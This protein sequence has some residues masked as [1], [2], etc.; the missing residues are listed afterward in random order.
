MT[1][2]TVTSKGQVTIPKE[3]RE[4]LG[5]KDRDRIAFIVEGKRAVIIPM[6]TTDLIS[7][8]GS[9]RATRPYPGEDAI[10]AEVGRAIAN[11]EV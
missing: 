1:V 2:A 3:V 5:I 10:W 8:R 11:G 4:A 9:L 7:L 6:K